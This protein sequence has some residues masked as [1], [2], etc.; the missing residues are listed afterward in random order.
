MPENNLQDG[1]WRLSR[2]AIPCVYAR[3]CVCVCVCVIDSRANLVK[4][5]NLRKRRS[6]ANTLREETVENTVEFMGDRAVDFIPSP[7]P[8]VSYSDRCFGI[9]V[10]K[11][12]GGF[13]FHRLAGILDI[14][15]AM[16]RLAMSSWDVEKFFSTESA[17]VG[18]RLSN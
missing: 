7:P 10:A 11:I 9:A 14:A 5:S 3:I 1:E 16:L 17:H 2:R 15:S 6:S 4:I 12:C 8:S 13:L 18:T